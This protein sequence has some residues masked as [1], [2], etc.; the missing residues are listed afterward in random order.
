MQQA[1]RRAWRIGQTEAVQ[2]VFLAYRNTLQANALKLAAQKL[3]SSLAVE[4]ELPADGLAAHG[5]DGD[6]SGEQRQHQRQGADHAVAELGSVKHGAGHPLI[7]G[8]HASSVGDAGR[9]TPLHAGRTRR[10][11]PREDGPMEE[12][13]RG[14]QES[15]PHE[16]PSVAPVSLRGGDILTRVFLGEV[17][18]EEWGY[19]PARYSANAS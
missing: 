12:G 10:R 9:T 11:L 7:S 6:E 18:P 17:A 2:V 5:D 3:Q 14:D 16:A 1:S 13:D 19:S 15:Q 8:E 4:G